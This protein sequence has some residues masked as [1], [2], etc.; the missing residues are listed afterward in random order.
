MT[1]G[2]F[3]DINNDN[4]AVSKSLNQSHVVSRIFT[5]ISS[6]SAQ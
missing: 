5:L 1:R 3:F 2:Y 6:L 4:P